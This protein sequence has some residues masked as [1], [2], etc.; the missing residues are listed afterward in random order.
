MERGNTCC[1]CGTSATK[2]QMEHVFPKSRGG[3]DT[4]DNLLPACRSCNSSKGAKDMVLW[5]VAQDRFPPIVVMSRYLKL[6]NAWCEAHNLMK[7]QWIT[8]SDVAW[9]FDK[10]SLRTNW[11]KHPEDHQLWPEPV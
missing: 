8:I 6:A 9:P 11:P 5:I 1:Y 2:I 4:G 10:Q 3:T 7:L